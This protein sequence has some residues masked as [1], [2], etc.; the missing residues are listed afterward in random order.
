MR[1]EA[2]TGRYSGKR[3]SETLS[4][5][6]RSVGANSDAPTESRPRHHKMAIFPVSDVI[7]GWILAALTAPIAMPITLERD[8]PRRRFLAR[9]TG[10]LT[11]EEALEFLRTAR[12]DPEMATWPL[13][14]DARGATTTVTT[15]EVAS[16]VDATQEVRGTSTIP[17]GHVAIIADD[18]RLFER[19]CLYETRL[20]AMGIRIVRVF[21]DCDDAE[22]WLEVMH[23]TRYF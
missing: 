5:H 18:E 19:F 3:G 2:W 7:T 12:G 21:R 11:I 1:V 9:V 10:L 17:R 8:I 14:F 16:I 23:A 22:R 20:F 13:I 4:C 6:T 15:D